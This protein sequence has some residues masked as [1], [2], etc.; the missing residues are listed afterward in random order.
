MDQL[1][2]GIGL[3]AFGNRNPVIEYKMTGYDM[4][5]EMTEAIEEDTVRLLLHVQIE[6]KIEREQ[7]AKVTGTNKDDS[8]AKAPVRRETK[9][10]QR[11]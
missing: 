1:R 7:V 4:F 8:V 2:Q 3:Q 5:N 6:Q 9:K 10:I 11:K